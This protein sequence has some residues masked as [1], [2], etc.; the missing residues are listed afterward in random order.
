MDGT[1]GEPTINVKRQ[2]GR[3]AG[4]DEERPGRVAE[5]RRVLQRPEEREGEVIT[6]RLGRGVTEQPGRVTP[7]LGLD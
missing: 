2:A 7:G 1:S 6:N 5:S 4:S 3:L